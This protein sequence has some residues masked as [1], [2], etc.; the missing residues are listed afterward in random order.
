MHPDPSDQDDEEATGDE[1]P[2]VKYINKLLVDAIRMGASDLHFEPYE[3]TYRVRYR[4]DG[5]FVPSP[6]PL[7]NSQLPLSIAFKSHVANGHFRKSVSH[8][9]VVLNSNYQKVK[10]L[11]SV[12]TPCRPYLVKN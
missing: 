2:I 10:R 6:I 8:K 3:K 1:A 12:L 4:V 5:V 11:T 9:M 7:F